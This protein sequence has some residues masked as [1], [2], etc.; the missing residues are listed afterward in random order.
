MNSESD[1]QSEI[2]PNQ[3]CGG[4]QMIELESP[5]IRRPSVRLVYTI[6]EVSQI[7]GISENSVRKAIRHDQIPHKRIGGRVVIPIKTFHDAM[8][9]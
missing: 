1:R 6:A 9:V 5:A 3:G 2:H 7:L 4:G 8:E